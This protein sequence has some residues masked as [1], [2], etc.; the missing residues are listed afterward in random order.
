MSAA[1]DE[2]EL[3]SKPGD[4]ILE[5]LEEMKMTQAE[6]AKRIGKTPSK[7]NDLITGKEPIT[8]TTAVQLEKVLGIDA[9]FWLNRE[10]LYREKLARIEQEEALEESM[11][12]LA[13]LPVSKLREYGY[14]KSLRKGT[15][16]VYE[17]LKFFAVD[18]PKEWEIVYVGN[19]VKTSFRRSQAYAMALGSMTAWLRLGEIELRKMNLPEFN[20][21]D[22]KICLEQV[23]GL[24][25]EHPEDF[26]AQLQVISSQAGV[27]VVYTVNLPNAP[28][29][30]AARWISGQ[31]VIQLTDR[32]KSNDHFWFT[33]FHEAGHILLHGKKEVFIEDFEGYDFDQ[34]K[35]EEANQF[36]EEWLLPK[37]FIEDVPA[38]E[39]TA[40]DIRRIARM[41]RTHPAIVLG[42]LQKLDLLG[43]AF[44][45]ELRMKVVLDYY[46][47]KDNQ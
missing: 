14:I 25:E 6:L 46:I 20:K 26:P 3:L 5:T 21:D 31:P 38:G 36:A 44:G 28:I 33:F 22:F 10:T 47:N 45:T 30:G 2:R 12:W 16:M 40:K 39:I 7:I 11:D 23:R 15:S 27:A 18:S 43:H 4:T 9:Q 17:F 8:V 42:R 29:S 1:M 41:Y 24:V 13:Q 35:E 19:Y 32:Y 34:E 37:S